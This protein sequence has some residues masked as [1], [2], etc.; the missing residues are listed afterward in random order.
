MKTSLEEAIKLAKNYHSGQKR[1]SGDDYIQHPLNVMKILK[2]CQFEEEELLI[3]AIMHD[4]C[5]DT[6]FCNLKV[7]QK[8]GERLGFVINALSKNK[9]SNINKKNKDDNKDYRFWL[10]LN[11]F[12]SGIM[13]DPYILFI[14]TADQIDNM[15]SIEVF[16]VKKQ[17]KKIK[18]IEDYFLPIYEKAYEVL[19]KKY[20]I[21][22]Q[23]LKKELIKLVQMKKEKI[24]L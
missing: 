8:F 24:K 2:D 3:A 12:S 18:E 23:K 9:K 10:Y 15:S 16:P 11:R 17:L 5:E 4:V 22:Y 6:I 13:H 7:T 20:K 1:L 21:Q 19:D 14:K